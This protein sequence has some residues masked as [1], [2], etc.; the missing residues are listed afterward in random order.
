[1]RMIGEVAELLGLETVKI[2]EKIITNKKVMAPFIEKDRGVTYISDEG[3][4]QLKVLFDLVEKREDTIIE[5][6]KGEE[7]IERHLQEEILSLKE[8]LET[9]KER[10]S[11]LDGEIKRMDEMIDTYL[12]ELSRS[13]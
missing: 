6:S 13:R 2:F 5:E 7:K 1:M 8:R 11:T 12:A 9:K 10:M 3:I 4:E